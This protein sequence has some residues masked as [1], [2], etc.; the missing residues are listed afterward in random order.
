MRCEYVAQ[1]IQLHQTKS[2]RAQKFGTT[3]QQQYRTFRP[4]R[5][6]KRQWQYI[7]TENICRQT[8]IAHT[9]THSFGTL[10]NPLRMWPWRT[11]FLFSYVFF[12]FPVSLIL[13]FWCLRT[14]QTGF[15]PPP[16]NTPVAARAIGWKCVYLLSR[17][18][19]LRFLERFGKASQWAQ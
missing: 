19:C 8:A 14:H 17:P 1:L 12:V 3:K 13:R 2:K 6:W 7:Y 5:N 16:H 10:T 15:S 11:R 4:Y 9:Y 18:V